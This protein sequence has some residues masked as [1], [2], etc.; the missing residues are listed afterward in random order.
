MVKVPP[1]RPSAAGQDLMACFAGLACHVAV[2]AVA[3]TNAAAASPR[4]SANV[5]ARTA[6]AGLP[7]LILTFNF[8]L[9]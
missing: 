6:E 8:Y 9:F 2:A 5:M 1:A 4:S 3:G 7:Y